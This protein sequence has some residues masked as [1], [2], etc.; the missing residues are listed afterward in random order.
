MRSASETR[1]TSPGAGRIASPPAGA[2]L[3]RAAFLRPATTTD[4]PC[5]GSVRALARPIPDPP[6]V[7]RAT[8]PFSRGSVHPADKCVAGLLTGARI[9]SRLH[10]LDCRTNIELIRWRQPSTAAKPQGLHRVDPAPCSS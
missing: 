10:L 1:V 2:V 3:S 6:P 7:T 9:D 8:S 5:R 4:A